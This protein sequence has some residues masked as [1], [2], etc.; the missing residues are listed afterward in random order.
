MLD[1][2]TRFRPAIEPFMALWQKLR[3]ACAAVFRNEKW[4]SM[5][6]RIA[7]SHM[8]AE[9]EFFIQPASD[10]IAFGIDAP[11]SSLDE[12]L[13]DIC[14]SGRFRVLLSGS[15]FEIFLTIAHAK[16]E[17]NAQ[18]IHLGPPF[19]TLHHHHESKL[20][21][22]ESHF[23]M[24]NDVEPQYNVIDSDQL[25]AVSSKLRVHTPSFNGVKDLLRNL[26]ARY[27]KNQNRTSLD[28][29]APLPFSISSTDKTVTI[30]GPSASLRQLS[31]VGFFDRD[32]AIAQL[33]AQGFEGN[34]GLAVTSGVIPWPE[35]S[36][37]GTL[38]LYYKTYEV[39]SVAVR[40]WLGTTN[41]KTQVQE[42]FDPGRSIF[43]RG[44]EGR[45]EQTGFELA[46]VR[47][48][49]E[50]RI[51]AVW[52]G[53]KQYQDRPDL[54]GC[55]EFENKWIVLLGECT[56]QKPSTKFTPLLTRKKD[57]EKLMQDD[58]EIRPT[59]FTCSTVSS[60]DK[61]QARQDGI[62]LVGADELAAMLHGIDQEWGPKEVIEYLNRLLTES[63][64][65]PIRWQR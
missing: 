14:T 8:D 28:I 25:N 36:R 11:L 9:P 57:L 48:L 7:L 21:L 17:S 65:I 27:D 6:T 51:P 22:G 3:I 41:W 38:F 49:N 39:G 15:K 30:A 12:L 24:W 29:I 44:L 59:V 42:F 45:K 31:V 18:K 2:P 33:P 60:A 61:E 40:R 20:E 50:L 34:T 35:H 10:F 43:N 13:Q 53:D 5:S 32:R 55:I 26:N 52:Y 23:Q 1:D 46:V 54:V 63:L 19:S 56:V 16:S 37:S 64:D 62:S 47:L 58:I 4:V